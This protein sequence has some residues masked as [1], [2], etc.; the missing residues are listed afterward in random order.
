MSDKAFDITKNTKYDGYQRGF[1][2]VVYKSF[3]KKSSG[4][5]V[6]SAPLETLR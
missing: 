2:S 3:N 1:V 5:A 4:C 6:T